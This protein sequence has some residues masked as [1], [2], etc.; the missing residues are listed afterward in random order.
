[1][2]FHVEWLDVNPYISQGMQPTF[3]LERPLPPS[4]QGSPKGNLFNVAEV[5]RLGKWYVPVSPL[6]LET[7]EWSFTNS[8]QHVRVPIFAYRTGRNCTYVWGTGLEFGARAL[9]SLKT[10]H[11]PVVESCTLVLGRECHDLG[12]AYRCYVGMAFKVK[13]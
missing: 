5:A 9:D 8:G 13:E 3:L 11:N 7:I 12:D 1:M 10:N 4:A 6:N 2:Q